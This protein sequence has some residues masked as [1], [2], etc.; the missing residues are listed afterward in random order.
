MVVCNHYVVCIAFKPSE[1]D[2]VLVVDP[3]RMIP[4]KISQLLFKTIAR[5]YA[6]VDQL[7]SRRKH[8]KLSKRN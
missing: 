8:V 2:T 3:N 6:Q 1:H 4:V 5:G 7:V